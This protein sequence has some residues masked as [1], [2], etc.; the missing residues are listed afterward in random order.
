VAVATA[1]VLLMSGCVSGDGGGGG[2]GG[3]ESEF[4]LRVLM[5]NAHTEAH[6]LSYSGGAPLE[7]SPDGETAES[8]TAIIVAYGLEVP[9]ELLVDG[10]PVMISDELPEGVPLD[11][12]GDLIAVIDVLEDGTAQPSENQSSGGALEPGRQVGKPSAVSICP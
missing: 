9:F 11:G 12:Q 1:L 4:V 5:I 10:T 8:C 6:T 2:G 7:D 3:D